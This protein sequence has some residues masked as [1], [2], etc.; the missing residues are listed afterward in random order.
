MLKVILSRKGFDSSAGGH[1]SP[2]L[3]DGKMLSL[4]IPHA[5]D[6]LRYDEIAAPG[7]K[8]LQEIIDELAAG[9]QIAGK[10]AHLDPDLMRGARP[11]LR[12]WR[13]ALGP[14]R[15]AA[16]HLKNQGVSVGDL[17]LFYGWFRHAEQDGDRLCFR[18]G[19][20][21]CH[22]IFGY[23]EIGEVLSAPAHTDLPAWLHDHPHAAPF[24]IAR[25]T[26]TIYVATRKSSFH[27]CYPGAGV[28]RFDKRN[29]LTKEGLSRSRWNLDPALFQ[30][31]T[32][33]Y[34]SEVAWHD[35][36][37][38]SYPRAQEYVIHADQPIVSWASQLVQKSRLWDFD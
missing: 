18:R 20:N 5:L 8:S 22:A 3:P 7:G 27:P 4:P 35:G 1:A 10:G 24:R 11:R 33:S 37:F 9:A 38:Q 16:T 14:G 25:A 15:A 26:N 21:G 32:I 29:V 30:N 13:P 12:G 23:L 34:H 6:T 31:K 36:Y 19:S 2:I 17:F 28:F